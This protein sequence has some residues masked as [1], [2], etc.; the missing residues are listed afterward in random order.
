[1]L[2]NQRDHVSDMCRAAKIEYY[3]TK[4]EICGSDQK[5]LY[6]VM[7]ELL[8][9]KGP[10]LLPAHDSSKDLAD[11]FCIFFTEK[12][13]SIRSQLDS[14]NSTDRHTILSPITS[15]LGEGLSKCT[16]MTAEEILKII[17]NLPTK[18]CSLYPLPTWLLKKTDTLLPTITQIIDKS[19]AS[20]TFPSSFKST[21]VR[22]LLKKQ[23]AYRCYHSTETAL[24]KV[25]NDLLVANGQELLCLS[26][27]S[28]RLCRVRHHRPRHSY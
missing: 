4:I 16:L 18:S 21:L 7:N 28:R 12:M 22:P 19:L 15:S 1:M 8:H 10:A 23:S 5:K 17:K 24:L 26:G 6:Q 14:I 3:Q 9:R 2:T 25:H 20:G 27:T 13:T 11:K